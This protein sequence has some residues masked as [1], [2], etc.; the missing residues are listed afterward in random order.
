MVQNAISK[1]I[2][3]ALDGTRFSVDLVTAIAMQETG[4]L[5]RVMVEENLSAAHILLRCVG[6]TDAQ[7]T[8]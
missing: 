6:R 3:A 5:W 1:K 2:E 7:G 4:Y 8:S